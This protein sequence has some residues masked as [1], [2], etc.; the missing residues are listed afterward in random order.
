MDQGVHLG[1]LGLRAQHHQKEIGEI[2]VL[3]DQMEYQV[4]QGNVVLQDLLEHP[5]HLDNRVV[6]VDQEQK[7]N[8]V[9]QEIE[10]TQDLQG[11]KVKEEAMVDLARME[12]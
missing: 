7:E 5:V 3:K 4:V 6:L 1:Q 9:S 11:L 10:V 8:L 12:F 2:R